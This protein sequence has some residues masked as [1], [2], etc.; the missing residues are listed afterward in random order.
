MSDTFV[1]NSVRRVLKLIRE[2]HRS[3]YRKAGDFSGFLNFVTRYTNWQIF[4][5][6][7]PD[8]GSNQA[9]DIK[10]EGDPIDSLHN[11]VTEAGI[12]SDEDYSKVIPG[13]LNISFKK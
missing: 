8:A 3:L 10:L 11:R 2:E 9:N 6:D 12:K 1:G 4:F 13:M 7:G 5:Q